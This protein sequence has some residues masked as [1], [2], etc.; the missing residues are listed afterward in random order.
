[1]NN[2][3]FTSAKFVGTARTSNAKLNKCLQRTPIVFSYDVPYDII[4][5]LIQLNAI[6]HVDIINIYSNFYKDCDFVSCQ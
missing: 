5:I 1:M 2:K 4:I 6:G 3:E